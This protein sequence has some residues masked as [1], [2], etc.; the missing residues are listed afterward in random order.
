MA[1]KCIVDNTR[2]EKLKK[3][4]ER[5]DTLENGLSFMEAKALREYI[6]VDSW[7]ALSLA[8]LLGFDK[9]QRAE[10]AKQKGMGK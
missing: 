1:V 9:G 6:E 4:V 3:T 8:F 10:K 2:L 5:V 7:D